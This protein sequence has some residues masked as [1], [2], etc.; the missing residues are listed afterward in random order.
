MRHCAQGDGDAL[1]YDCAGDEDML[2]QPES[3]FGSNQRAAHTS[4]RVAFTLNATWTFVLLL[5]TIYNAT[6]R[7]TS[8]QESSASAE[9]PA[10]K[11]S[12]IGELRTEA[13][14]VPRLHA[15]AFADSPI[16]WVLGT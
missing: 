7:E 5:A 3:H 16:K 14:A 6:S 15:R 2:F 12:D 4:Q 9:C 13:D 10:W 8:I 1:L 11:S